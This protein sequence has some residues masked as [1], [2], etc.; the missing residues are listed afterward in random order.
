M[1][2]ALLSASIHPSS[3]TIH[4]P[5]SNY[6]TLK[7]AVSYGQLPTKGKWQG[8]CT[9]Q[10]RSINSSCVWYYSLAKQLLHVP[11]STPVQSP[12]SCVHQ[13]NSQYSF[14]RIQITEKS[15]DMVEHQALTRRTLQQLTLSE[16]CTMAHDQQLPSTGRTRAIMTGCTATAFKQCA[17]HATHP[18]HPPPILVP[19]PTVLREPPAV[20]TGHPA[21]LHDIKNFLNFFKSEQEVRSDVADTNSRYQRSRDK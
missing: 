12:T 15:H 11:S 13:S 16:L 6:C 5:L 21:Q 1:L 8:P 3:L 7:H 18:T 2:T 14:P 9:S 10:C 17:Q 4:K 19:Q 20:W